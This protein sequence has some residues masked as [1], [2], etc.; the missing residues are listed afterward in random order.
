MTDTN[1]T[2][3]NRTDTNQTGH[4]NRDVRAAVFRPDD[5]RLA[6][7]VELLD[8][9]GADPVPDPML[10]VEPTGR[11]P[12]E[13]AD[14]AILTSTTGVELVSEAGWDSGEATICA[15]G[16]TTAEALKTAGYTVEVVP[17]K[18]TSSGLVKILEEEVDGARVEIARSDHGSNVLPEGLD[19][20]GAYVHETVLYELVRPEG[21]GHSVELA[22]EGKLDA[23]LFTSPLTVEH[24]LEAAEDRGLRE[25]T[26]AGLEDAVV[27]VI[28]PP[29]RE[30]AE[31]LGIQVD[32][33][34]DEADFEVLATT[35][36]E[37][38]APSYHGSDD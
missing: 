33:V 30:T 22:A 8:A 26:I 18:Y 27:G 25:E 7:A 14:F 10:A 9:L 2:D 35:V 17:E 5:E 1:R 3:T 34:P 37:E 13:D 24:F 4:V 36:V 12:R 15:I 31:G 11:T 21:S 6:N 32:L 28:G 23:V 20:A 19:A 29:T 16:P 38:A